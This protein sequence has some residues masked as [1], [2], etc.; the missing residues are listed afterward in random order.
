[1][2]KDMDEQLELAHKVVDVEDRSNRKIYVTLWRHSVDKVN[3]FT[4]QVRLF[5]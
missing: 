5:S 1:M 2:S 3:S 4:A